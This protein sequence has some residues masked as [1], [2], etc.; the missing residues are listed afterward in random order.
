MTP[1]SKTDTLEAQEMASG[2]TSTGDEAEIQQF[3]AKALESVAAIPD[4]A[5]EDE[6]A[7]RREKAEKFAL[8]LQIDGEPDHRPETAGIWLA[9]QRWLYLFAS[10]AFDP[11]LDLPARPL[12][13]WLWLAGPSSIGK[14]FLAMQ[15]YKAAKKCAPSTINGRIYRDF[16]S[17]W[18]R[19]GVASAVVNWYDL[20]GATRK[21]DKTAYD[22]MMTRAKDCDIVL[23]DDIGGESGHATFADWELRDLQEIME[24]RA[25]SRGQWTIITSQKTIAQ[26]GEID[27]RIEGRILRRTIPKT[28]WEISDHGGIQPTNHNQ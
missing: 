16:D 13:K 25:R 1:E 7:T 15:A 11:S 18:D 23:L 10:K 28:R 12:P 27:R 24:A 5:Q 3:L 4:D 8:G 2:G 22:D 21:T 20:R 9:C 14:T 6:R 17:P 26:I 19:R